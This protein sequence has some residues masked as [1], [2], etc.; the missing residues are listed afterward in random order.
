[1]SL[2]RSGSRKI[3][4]E[5]VAY[6]WTVRPRPTYAQGLAQSG[7]CVGVE[8]WENPGQTLHIELP[9]AR[10]G[11]WMAAPGYVVTPAE[12]ARWILLALLRGW[13]P[14]QRGSTFRMTIEEKDLTRT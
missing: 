14:Q 3:I 7:L 6:R 11:N 12:L 13:C 2:T 8:L 9:V 4:H 5:G 1:M 10:P